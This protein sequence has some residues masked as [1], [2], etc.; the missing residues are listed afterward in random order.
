[1]THT[2]HRR[3]TVDSLQ[4]D[5]VVLCIAAM[6]VN[7]EGSTAKL[8]EFIRICMR[9]NPLNA[10]SVHVGNMYTSS[11]DK[12][13]EG[14]RGHVHAVFDRHETVTQVLKD[15]KKADL[16][17]SVVVSGLLDTV[18][19]CCEEAGLKRHTVEM[20]LGVWGKVE[21]LESQEVLEV[22]TM[23][24]HGLVAGNLVKTLVD[25]IRNGRTTARQASEEIAKQCV[26]G[27]FNASRAEELLK[28][29]ASRPV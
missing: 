22:T 6:G 11:A 29:M 5:Y 19:H 27:I 1:M 17:L 23:C 24:G 8:Q 12:M 13:I 25:D 20:S 2:L 4:Q 26:C 15:L 14:V 21:K 7:D 3:G 10:G 28:A 18:D 9:H 16:G